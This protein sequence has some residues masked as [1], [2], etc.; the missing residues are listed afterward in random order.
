MLLQLVGSVLVLAAFVAL[1]RRRIES[2]SSTYL[3]AN[4]FGATLLAIDAFHLRQWGFLAL[5]ATWAL[6]SAHGLATA[7]ARRAEAA[8]PDAT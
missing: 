8:P 3:A 1:A 7:G 6:V 5:E 4:A 2:T